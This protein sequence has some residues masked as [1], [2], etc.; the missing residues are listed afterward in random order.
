MSLPRPPS[1]FDGGDLRD[2]FA[3]RGAPTPTPTAHLLGS[4]ESHL[5]EQEVTNMKLKIEWLYSQLITRDQVRCCP[6][7]RLAGDQDAELSIAGGLHYLAQSLK[8]MEQRQAHT[9]LVLGEAL[10]DAYTRPDVNTVANAR[11]D[12]CVPRS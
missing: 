2:A 4:W 8:A 9:E 3:R 5:L 1:I 7:P 6:G 11:H 10:K 12:P